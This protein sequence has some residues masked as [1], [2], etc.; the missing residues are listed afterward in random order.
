MKNAAGPILAIVAAVCFAGKAVLIRM[1]YAAAPVDA[2][3]LLALRMGF[4]LPICLL[5]LWWQARDGKQAPLT[6][7]EWVTMLWLGFLGYYLA[8]LLDFWGLEYISAALERILLFTYPTLV[9]LITAAVYG[10]AIRQRELMA[11]LLTVAGT[12]VSFANDLRLTSSPSA[13]YKGAAL[14]LTS[15]LTYAV[16]L[17]GSGRNVGRIGSL[18]F[19]ALNI[20]IASGFLLGQFFLTR[21]ASSL[22]LPAKIYWLGLALAWFSTGLPI[23]LTA[24]AIRRSGASR[25]SIAASIGPIITI[26]LGH[27]FLGEPVTI[28]QMAG[29]A[30]VLGGVGLITMAGSSAEA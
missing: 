7:H 28:M 5:L 4:S 1:A 17:I 3:T 24:E 14:V 27:I 13:L 30:L 19:S 22:I 9:V 15:A 6:K 20:S 8:S 2:V 12:I 10:K 29:A 18:R 26:W 21:P 11:L 16:F 23:F 25:V